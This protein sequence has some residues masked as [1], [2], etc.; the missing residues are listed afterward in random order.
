MQCRL[1][2]EVAGRGETAFDLL[3]FEKSPLACTA[4]KMPGR[5]F[6][7]LVVGMTAL[8]SRSP[9]PLVWRA[10]DG[11]TYESSADENIPDLKNAQAQYDNAVA[12]DQRGNLGSA[13]AGYRKVVRRFPNSPYAPPSQLKVGELLEKGGD[14]NASFKAY[15]KLIEKYPRTEDFNRA[16]DSQYKIALLFLDGERMRLLG[17]PTLPSVGRAIQMFEAIVKNAPYSQYA[18]LCQFNIGMARER[19]GKVDEAI[20]AYQLVLDRYPNTDIADDAQYQMGYV[21][22]RESKLGSYD[23][24]AN[25]EAQ[26]AFEDFIYR[27]PKSEK[28]PQARKNIDYLV[29]HQGEGSLVIARFYD[30]QRKY[31]SAAIYYRQ[32]IAEQPNT[33]AS[34]EAAK[35]L[36]ELEEMLG[37][38]ALV[39]VPEAADTPAK[40]AAKRRVQAKVDTASRPDYVGPPA[41]ANPNVVDKPSRKRE[42]SPVDNRT[43]PDMNVGDDTTPPL[44][45]GGY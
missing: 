24:M 9:A 14:F 17:I 37:K 31:K 28:V 5:I 15:Q 33:E 45:I 30:K 40:L 1:R 44:P 2:G 11:V 27:Y 42:P 35:R 23:T 39:V 38:Q 18:P 7:L 26:M 43:S 32:V 13:L 16:L 20:K 12:Y 41:P 21:L 19:Q 4:M 10:D 34:E 25:Q 29:Q 6:L 3:Q 22:M 8:P 36:A